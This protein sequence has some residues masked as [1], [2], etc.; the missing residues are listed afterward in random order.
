MLILK[1]ISKK[2]SGKKILDAISCSIAPGSIAIFLGP[3]GVG[4]STLLRALNNLETIDSGEVIL[5]GKTIDLK[6]VHK[7]HTIGMV[8]QHFALFEHWTV[9]QNI[10]QP[11]IISQKKTVLQAERRAI[12]L[13]D[14]YQLLEH[15]NKPINRLSGGQK[16][17]LAIARTLALSPQI[18]CLD[19][20]TSALD[21][22][23]SSYVAQTIIHLKNN[24]Y[25]VL[26]ATH[27][28]AFVQKLPAV[29]YLMQEGRIIESISTEQYFK[30]PAQHPHIHA[31]MTGKKD[32]IEK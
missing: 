5:D 25:F 31:F 2:V 9:I 6:I 3:S 7:T 16:Q 8:F 17:R 15:K 20:P 32:E 23:L 11:L 24:G 19:E 10:M 14:D 21:P 26:L 4:K 28:T 12:S 13:L 29:L 22:L 1:N 30:N 18:I 27:D